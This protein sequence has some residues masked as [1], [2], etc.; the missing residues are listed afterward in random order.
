[1]QGKE[2]LLRKLVSNARTIIANQIGFPVGCERMSRILFWLKV[3]EE[4]NYE[5]FKTYADATMCIPTGTE[6]LH[7]TREALRRHGEQLNEVNRKYHEQVIDACFD[8]I[9]KY[10]EK[11][12]RADLV[13]GNDD[14]LFPLLERQ[15]L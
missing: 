8:I 11:K 10:A 3:H 9:D 7:C 6:R 14:D 1:M 13:K 4:L 5:V 2:I 12:L 15:I